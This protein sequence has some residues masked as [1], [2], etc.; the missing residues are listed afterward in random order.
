LKEKVLFD[1]RIMHTHTDLHLIDLL[2]K[3]KIVQVLDYLEYPREFYGIVLHRLIAGKIPNVEK[4]WTKF[5]NQLKDAAKKA[6]QALNGVNKGLAQTF[7]D[8]LRDEFSEGSLQ[9]DILSL[10]F[11]IDFTGE[12]KEC[13]DEEK[14]KFQQDC[15]K[16]LI[17]AIDSVKYLKCHEEFSKELS[18]KVVNYM[19]TLTNKAVL[20][21]CDTYCPCCSSLCIEAINHNTADIPHDSVHQPSGVVGVHGKDNEELRYKTCIRIRRRP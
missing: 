10:A 18:P 3:N 13:D 19:T 17:Q 20:P 1:A 4:E 6:A 7:V 2:E 5:K 14:T 11:S 16:E 8:K 9:S 21:R 12:Y 15:E